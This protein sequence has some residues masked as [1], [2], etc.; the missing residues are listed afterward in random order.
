M[1][2][3]AGASKIQRCINLV[4]SELE[5]GGNEVS[6]VPWQLSDASTNVIHVVVDDT[7]K[8]LLTTSNTIIFGR[9]IHLLA[10]TRRVLW[11]SGHSSR[12]TTSP[13]EAALITGL[14]RTAHAENQDLTMVTLD[15]EKSLGEPTPK[16]A[17][18]I[19]G[20]L[21][22]SFGSNI[23]DL[24]LIEREYVYRDGNLMIPRLVPHHKMN[25]Y[26]FGTD[27]QNNFSRR[28]SACAE[29]L[30][31]NCSDGTCS[32]TVKCMTEDIKT[33]SEPG[34]CEVDLDLHARGTEDNHESQTSS[35]SADA[36][37]LI[38][39]AGI[40]RAT[41]SGV[42]NLRAGHRVIAIATATT[43]NFLRVNYQNVAL[44]PDS[45]SFSMAASSLVAFMNAYQCLLASTSL[46]RGQSILIA[47]LD[48]V[49]AQAAMLIAE[50]VGAT[51]VIIAK[52]ANEQDTLISRFGSLPAHVVLAT[53]QSTPETVFG[54]IG[55][56]GVDVLLSG[57]MRELTSDELACVTFG[58]LV[59]RLVDSISTR[60]VSLDG[61]PAHKNL[62]VTTF[63]L[64]S[65][66]NHQPLQTVS[67]LASVVSLILD[68]QSRPHAANLARQALSN[69]GETKRLQ[70]KEQTRQILPDSYLDNEKNIHFKPRNSIRLQYDATYIVVGGL[71]DLGSRMVR[72]M[73]GWGASNIVIVTRR[74][75][76][77]AEHSKNQDD[78]NLISPDTK[79]HWWTCDI[80]DSGQV[81]SLMAN[82]LSSGLPPLKGIIHSAL[83]L[84]VRLN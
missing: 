36:A 14:A 77:A 42:S 26:M 21:L 75:F 2:A 19:H 81:I 79:L 48:S 58:G 55:Q 9:I 28:G 78:V 24:S 54:L 40:I 67:S 5:S 70:P 56:K 39:Y 65:F 41:G 1:V 82:L 20:V 45:I 13:P 8:P 61:L 46:R 63:D 68:I 27:P 17:S 51:T 37:T 35:S 6:L 18:A 52:N 71:G 59:Y 73:A 34:D 60:T 3:E 38:G 44:L 80:A 15:T 43:A 83:K 62:K 25:D 16:L 69:G 12:T 33:E 50:H 7:S 10:S 72:F 22:R 84:H 4:K 11:I 64:S 29:V 30:E 49:T 47:A 53:G 32:G 23:T 57:S 31:S 66:I 76:N 74:A